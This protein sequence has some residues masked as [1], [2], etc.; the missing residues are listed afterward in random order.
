[1]PCDSIILNRV[2]LSVANMQLLFDALETM[3]A[4]QIK[5][6]GKNAQFILDGNL[7]RIQN[8]QLVGSDRNLGAMADRIK[9][10]YS[11]QCVTSAAKRF[12]WI[13]KDATE[14]TSTLIKRY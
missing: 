9:R 2:N 11:K 13:E 1:M 12:G 3:G 8:G 5:I 7:Y 14:T 6:V 10:A 4:D